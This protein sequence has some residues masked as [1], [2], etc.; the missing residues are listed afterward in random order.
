MKAYKG[1]GMDGWVARWY[2]R[3]R[4]NDIADFRQQARLVAGQLTPGAHLLEVAPG[5]GFFSIELARL[6]RYTITGLD[7]S[8]TFVEIA[9][10]NA[11]T[12]GVAFD[13]RQGNASAMPF[14]DASFDFTYCSAAFKNFSDPVGALN[15]MYRVLRPGG[16]AIIDDLR[17]DVSPDDID[18]YI[19]QS[20][21]T[22][23]DAWLTGWTFRCMLI[24]RAY[25]RDELKAMAAESRF[26]SCDIATNDIGVEVR[27]AKLA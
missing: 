16:Q 6:G 4:Q 22:A 7:V 13:F 3:T 27:L 9:Q 19:R 11:R 14:A 10:A 5:P 2:A 24:K 23:F 18:A 8:T 15:E 21:R 17:K 12:A 26:G 20:G 25:A 1:M